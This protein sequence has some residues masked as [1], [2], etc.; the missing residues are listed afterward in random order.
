VCFWVRD[1]GQGLSAEQ[2]ERL[3]GEFTRLHSGG[4][5]SPHGLGQSHGLGLSIVKRIIDKLGGEVSV[6]SQ[7][8]VG[9][10]FRF[11]LPAA[12]PGRR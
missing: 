10:T 3:F 8:G 4:Q 5:A 6:Q 2:M 7:L 12:N 1:N 11:T 9:S